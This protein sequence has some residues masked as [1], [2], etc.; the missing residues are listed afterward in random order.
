MS[1]RESLAILRESAV[2]PKAPPSLLHQFQNS[3]RIPLNEQAAVALNSLRLL[4]HFHENLSNLPSDLLLLQPARRENLDKETETYLSSA[5]ILA[6]AYLS[7]IFPFRHAQ[8]ILEWVV[9]GLCAGLYGPD[10]EI[11]TLLLCALPFH[12]TPQF[13]LFVSAVV[14]PR[15][16][17]GWRWLLPISHDLKPASLSFLIK[18]SPVSVHLLTVDWIFKLMHLKIPTL[19]ASLFLLNASSRWILSAEPPSR[20]LLALHALKCLNETLDRGWC[21]SNMLHAFVVFYSVGLLKGMDGDVL[22]MLLNSVIK[23]ICSLDDSQNSESRKA[24]L[25]LFS[26][27]LLKIDVN[28]LIPSDVISILELPMPIL[29][30]CF[31]DGTRFLYFKFVRALILSLNSDTNDL[32]VNVLKGLKVVFSRDQN[33]LLSN[34]LICEA[35]TDILN[36]LSQHIC[37]GNCIQDDSG[38]EDWKSPL[39][40]ILSTLTLGRFSAATLKGVRRH[41]AMRSAPTCE[42]LALDN[43]IKSALNSVRFGMESGGDDVDFSDSP[44]YPLIF[45]ALDHP[46]F[47]VRLEA[48]NKLSTQ[49]NELPTN[50]TRKDLLAKLISLIDTETHMKILESSCTV[51]VQLGKSSDAKMV[52]KAVASR[53]CNLPVAR[54]SKDD[55]HIVLSIFESVVDLCDGLTARDESDVCAFLVGGILSK[56][57]CPKSENTQ[58][59]VR[60]FTADYFEHISGAEYSKRS[61]GNGDL[62]IYAYIAS[63]MACSFDKM[64]RR[65]ISR[66][67]YAV[68]KW[69]IPWVTAITSTWLECPQ[70]TRVQ[71]PY[72]HR[73]AV[74]LEFLQRHIT[75]LDEVDIDNVV[76]I[77][78]RKLSDQPRSDEYLTSFQSLWRFSV[79]SRRSSVIVNSVKLLCKVLELDNA[80]SVL[81][82]NFQAC[83]THFL[84]KVSMRWYFSLI[85]AGPSKALR[86]WLPLDV[87]IA[88]YGNEAHLRD[89]TKMF[90]QNA[91]RGHSKGRLS[92]KTK[93]LFLQISSRTASQLRLSS[94][95]TDLDHCTEPQEFTVSYVNQ[96]ILIPIAQLHQIPYSLGDVP[97]VQKNFKKFFSY[98]R[99]SPETIQW[100]NYL[101]V[102]RAFEGCKITDEDVIS[103]LY[104]MLGRLFEIIS[105]DEKC[106]ML[107]CYVELIVRCMRFLVNLS[108]ILFTSEKVVSFLEPG[109]SKLFAWNGT[110]V[111]SESLTL[112]HLSVLS[113][114]VTLF[115]TPYSELSKNVLESYDCLVQSLLI[116]SR[117]STLVG[118]FAKTFLDPSVCKFVSISHLLKFIRRINN[119]LVSESELTS[120]EKQ[121]GGVSDVV[122]GASIGALVVLNKYLSLD[123]CDSEIQTYSC[124]I[125]QDLCRV[126][127][128]LSSY[129]RT[130]SGTRSDQVL[131]TSI[132]ALGSLY[133]FSGSYIK[134]SERIPPTMLFQLFFTAQ[135][136][137]PNHISGVSQ[138]M[139]RTAVLDLFDVHGNLILPTADVLNTFSSLLLA[140]ATDSQTCLLELVSC[141][142]RNGFGTKRL[143]QVL[144]NAVL[145]Q[146]LY[147]ENDHVRFLVIKCLGNFEDCNCAV[148]TFLGE[149]VDQLVILTPADL[150]TECSSLLG[151]LNISIFSC[152]TIISKLNEA[153]RCHVAYSYIMHPSFIGRAAEFM[154]DS[155]ENSNGERKS[156]EEGLSCLLLSITSCGN[157]AIWEDA[158]TAILSVFT[159][160]GLYTCLSY[161]LGCECKE[162]RIR[163]LRVFTIKVSDLRPQSSSMAMLG[164]SFVDQGVFVNEEGCVLR[165]MLEVLYKRLDLLYSK[166]EHS[167]LAE[168]QILIQSIEK[169]SRVIDNDDDTVIVNILLKTITF[170]SERLS[171]LESF[172]AE[173][174]E[175]FQALC[176]N[177]HFVSSAISR[178]GQRMVA[179]IPK[180][181]EAAISI[182]EISFEKSDKTAACRSLLNSMVSMIE[183]SIQV[184]VSV[185]EAT[186]SFFG[187]EFLCRI[188]RQFL[189]RDSRSTIDV[190]EF[191]M[192]RVP[193]TTSVNALK[194]IL[195]QSPESSVAGISGILRCLK[196]CVVAGGKV[197]VKTKGLDLL[198]LGIQCIDSIDYSKSKDK[199][200]V[201]VELV[202]NFENF[203]EALSLKIPESVFKMVF[204]RLALWS[205][206]E[207][208]PKCPL[209]PDD[210]AADSEKE[211]FRL[212][213]FHKTTA[214]LLATLQFMMAPYFF[215]VIENVLFLIATNFDVSESRVFEGRGTKKLSGKK[216]K[217]PSNDCEETRD[218]YVELHRRLQ[219]ACM[220]GLQQFLSVTSGNRLD[221]SMI[222]E[223]LQALLSCFESRYGKCSRTISTLCTLASHVSSNLDVSDLKDSSNQLLLMLSRELLSRTK[224]SQAELRESALLAFKAVAESVGNDI[225]VTLPES[226]P[227]FAEVI[228]DENSRVQRAAKSLVAT[229]EKF[230]GESILEQIR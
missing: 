193:L 152:L 167:D 67:F 20:R 99:S 227:V 46:D 61:E 22:K 6:S 4:S 134:V 8:R 16:R 198:E 24:L 115:P 212:F 162:T 141:L 62:D 127:E 150:G 113:S 136:H 224:S 117:K 191:A 196:Q 25:R 130:S 9:N 201:I 64:S 34:D 175:R 182:I 39:V 1:V 174:V 207:S 137:T 100:H 59:L 110:E 74:S 205:K 153:V 226:L 219:D 26:V 154:N 54:L 206:A 114:C 200:F 126:I 176:T 42:Y 184:C 156:F 195:N 166:Y 90:C 151:A 94:R 85:S 177:L 149:M 144:A 228:D 190:L 43:V 202:K 128:T 73:L 109:I 84:Q 124:D 7:P 186:P 45:L 106:S 81:K 63:I 160:P 70:T 164:K 66:F 65:D 50:K 56:M 93:N 119:D 181:L 210:I 57:F 72:A 27:T 132:E 188:V 147:R 23:A 40:S 129:S 146:S 185:L 108:P 155:E 139:L 194:R 120:Q 97:R 49:C 204:S 171:L 69:K 98:M 135:N 37:F 229:M 189:V 15:P 111:V 159:L 178:F 71:S 125:N 51:A 53:L 91:I 92:P 199:H 3:L 161:I 21:D 230:S 14:S 197:E 10:E 17:K 168:E 180:A 29:L 122:V 31:S 158:A 172:K 214:K 35:V 215:E 82:A 79:S 75:C 112:L 203:L 221:D 80:L 218:H 41:Y 30:S 104:I 33:N 148:E 140:D 12:A 192:R 5:V 222:A 170:L 52:F 86:K 157:G 102:F 96:H 89:E 133:R 217:E 209:N 121:I 173:D 216:R 18:N 88:F 142:D 145:G 48:L 60:S 28:F 123:S 38:K 223:S 183:E 2:V 76:S 47:S 116:Q 103:Q 83:H 87:L 32:D 44:S 77:C 220:A 143:S 68:F 208:R 19:Y 105:F 107:M 58:I 78:Y 55:S 179:V 101:S 13:P 95:Q 36:A 165:K 225:I 169:L 187:E 211:L 11:N 138:R 213:T 163:S 131:L 118:S